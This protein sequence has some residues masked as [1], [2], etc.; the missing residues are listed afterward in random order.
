MALEK[1][2]ALVSWILE[3]AADSNF[4]KG[5]LAPAARRSDPMSKSHDDIPKDWIR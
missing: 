1:Y 2:W 4:G 5:G 3:A